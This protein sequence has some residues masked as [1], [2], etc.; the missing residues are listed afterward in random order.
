MHVHKS[1]LPFT[2]GY[3]MEAEEILSDFS[4]QK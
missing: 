1:R 2:T 4:E 3:L